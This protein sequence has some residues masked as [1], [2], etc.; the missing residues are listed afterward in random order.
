MKAIFALL[1]IV[2]VSLNI[3]AQ[4]LPLSSGT[5]SDLH[6]IHFIDQDNGWVTGF[7]NLI[8]KTYNGGETWSN[9]GSH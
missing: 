8:N 3:S 7:D 9:T 2:S 1:L 5:D 4:W 6:S